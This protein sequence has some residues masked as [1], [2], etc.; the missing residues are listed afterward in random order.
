MNCKRPHKLPFQGVRCRC[1]QAPSNYP[2]GAPAG[3][4][5]M[6]PRH[7]WTLGLVLT[8]LNIGVGRCILLFIYIYIKLNTV[9]IY[10]YI[11]FTYIYYIKYLAIYMGPEWLWTYWETACVFRFRWGKHMFFMLEN[12]TR[13]LWG[14]DVAMDRSLCVWWGSVTFLDISWYIVIYVISHYVI[15]QNY[16][17]I[18]TL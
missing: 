2:A 15:C 16:L 12:I 5:I 11:T 14:Y 8:G 17:Q 7:C 10:I 6:G 3:V 1:Q 18:S 4:S 9:C 13:S